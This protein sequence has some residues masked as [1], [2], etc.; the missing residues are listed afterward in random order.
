MGQ[1]ENTQTTKFFTYEAAQGGLLMSAETL[2]LIHRGLDYKGIFKKIGL[3]RA[4]DLH[5]LFCSFWRAN[6]FKT[7]ESWIL[8]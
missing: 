2:P 4:P 7:K 5:H 8:N 1:L 3:P 6:H